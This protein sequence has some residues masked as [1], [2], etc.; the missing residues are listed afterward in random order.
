MT[1]SHP[2]K[3]HSIKPGNNQQDCEA[4]PLFGLPDY[5]HLQ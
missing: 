3:G 5:I 1:N 4:P 2:A